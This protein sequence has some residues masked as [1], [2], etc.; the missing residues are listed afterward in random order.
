MDTANANFGTDI[1][2]F[3][4][5]FSTMDELKPTNNPCEKI[6]DMLEKWG[7]EELPN[8][9]DLLKCSVITINFNNIIMLGRIM[10]DS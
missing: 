1:S 6:K 5:E 9:D 3:E 7:N 2:T 10:A 4:K 8:H